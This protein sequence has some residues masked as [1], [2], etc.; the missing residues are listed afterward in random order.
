LLPHPDSQTSTQQYRAGDAVG[1]FW[2]HAF[3]ELGIRWSLLFPGSPWRDPNLYGHQLVGDDFWFLAGRWDTYHGKV[4]PARI[5]P[6]FGWTQGPL[7]PENPL[8]LE[9]W[10]TKRLVRDGRRKVLFYGDSYVGGHSE[11]ANW[12]PVLL[13]NQLHGVDVLHLGVGGYGPDQMHLLMLETLPRVDRPHVVLMGV[14]SFSFD[15][16]SQGVR[17][18]QKPRF[19]L[20]PDGSLELI[21]VPIWRSPRLYYALKGPSFWSYSRAA[22]RRRRRPPERTDF[23]FEAKIPLNRAIIAANKRV[24]REVG[25]HLVYVL[26]HDHEQ[27]L[28]PDRRDLFFVEELAAQGVEAIDTAE[29]LLEYARQ[30][31]TD[32]SELY[33]GG[34]HNDLGNRVL[35]QALAQ[36]L[37]RFDMAPRTGAA[38]R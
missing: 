13:E 18:Y 25:A 21:N 36:R 22:E 6:R 14:M 19:R 11:P 4:A 26:F 24:A 10:T 8:G 7:T 38:T 34:H 33:V 35:A 37:A 20:K 15:R 17:S 31:D 23:E 28:R 3:A 12:L 2:R 1:G 5:H 32:A 29:P 16:A 9:P 27:L 30:H